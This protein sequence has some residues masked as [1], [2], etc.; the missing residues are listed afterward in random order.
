VRPAFKRL[1]E[2]GVAISFDSLVMGFSALVEPDAVEVRQI[3]V[4]CRAVVG[5]EDGSGPAL[6]RPVLCGMIETCRAKGIQL[7]ACGIET[8]QELEDVR[9]MGFRLG[10][11]F[12]IREPVPFETAIEDLARG[13]VLTRDRVEPS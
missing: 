1:L 13:P 8:A 9:A 3:K 12:H 7:I 4:D 5:D 6:A 11:G 2:R 10:Q